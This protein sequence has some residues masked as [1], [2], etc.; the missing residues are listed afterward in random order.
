MTQSW[1]RLCPSDRRV[2]VS[3]HDEEVGVK[4]TQLSNRGEDGED[5]IVPNQLPNVGLQVCWRGW[6]IFRHG[7]FAA[8]F[9]RTQPKEK[10]QTGVSR[11]LSC[12]NKLLTFSLEMG[13]DPLYTSKEL[14]T[15]INYCVCY[16]FCVSF[17]AGRVVVILQKKDTQQTLTHIPVVCCNIQHRRCIDDAVRRASRLCLRGPWPGVPH[18]SVSKSGKSITEPKRRT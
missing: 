1:D 7:G 18:A 11:S 9:S 2:G 5:A 15:N 10:S 17:W 4:E 14:S 8:S 13:Q 6:L 16:A 3:R 12:G